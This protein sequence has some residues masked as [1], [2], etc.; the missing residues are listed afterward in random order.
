MAA[1][2]NLCRVVVDRI[3]ATV[4]DVAIPESAVRRAMLTSALKMEPGET[5]AAFRERVLDALIDQHLQYD[6]AVR[7]GPATPDAADVTAEVQKLR[8]RLK[9]QGRDPDKEFAD[10]GLTPEELRATVER[11]LIVQRHLVE[12]FRSAAVASARAYAEEVEKWMKELRQRARIERHALAPPYPDGAKL[13][14]L[15]TAPKK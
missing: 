5:A 14:V 3:A 12:R 13:I 2:D 15:S 1:P 8:E 10:A 6:D 11:Q 7:F 9:A 4:D